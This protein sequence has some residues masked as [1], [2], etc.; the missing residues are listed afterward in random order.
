MQNM[1]RTWSSILTQVKN[2]LSVG[3][4]GGKWEEVRGSIGWSSVGLWWVILIKSGVF[5]LD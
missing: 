1:L 3:W 4:G 2:G 5:W